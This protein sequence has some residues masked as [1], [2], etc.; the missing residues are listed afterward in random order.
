MRKRARSFIHLDR[1]VVGSARRLLTHHGAGAEEFARVRL[2]A[3]IEAG[4]S[5]E[6]ET[7]QAIAIA[8]T[9]LCANRRI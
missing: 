8:V 2:E 1:A 6:I 9:H 7:W 4:D 3:A 5:A